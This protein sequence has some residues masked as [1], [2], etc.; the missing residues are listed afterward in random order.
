MKIF[1]TRPIPESGIELLSQEHEV[2]VQPEQR[3]LGP[4]ELKALV[5]GADAILSMVTDK[6]DTEVL[7]AA[8][9]RL[10]IVANYAVGYDNIDLAAAKAANVLV[11]NTP[12]VLN[13]AVAEHTFALAMTVC[14]RVVQADQF[15]RKGRYHGWDP[16]GFLGIELKGKT[17]GVIGLGRIG[18]RVGQ[19][20]SSFGMSVVYNDVKPNLE[21]EGKL[22]AKFLSKQ[23]LLKTSD[24]VT[25]HVPLLETTRHLISKPE[26]SIMKDT[27]VLI[28]TSRGAVVDEAALIEALKSKKIFGAGLD[29]FE[30]EPKLTAGLAELPNVV[31][32]PHIASAT[33]EAR[34]AMSK[35]AAE[36]ILA[37]L[38]GRKPPNLVKG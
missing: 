11:T 27:A 8:G 33:H 13:E 14:R 7:A 22:G 15:T 21:F 25:L 10:K 26:L 2:V 23:E 36:N 20:A 30:N 34:E 6:I 3:V 18:S 12:Q 9:S 29:V 31:L 16:K 1:V 28:N 17:I 35:L 32:T 4:D 37:A 5:K 24:I 38:E 19:I